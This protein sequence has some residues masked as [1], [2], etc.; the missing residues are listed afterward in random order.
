MIS[1]RSPQ[2]NWTQCLAEEI[3]REQVQIDDYDNCRSFWERLWYY[4]HVV[5]WSYENLSTRIPHLRNDESLVCGTKAELSSSFLLI[6][7][8]KVDWM[9]DGKETHCS[10]SSPLSS[11]SVVIVVTVDCKALQL[12]WRGGARQTPWELRRGGDARTTH[13]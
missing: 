4:K 3:L 11:L 1:G 8:T 10:V 12:Q 6:P 7:T 9:N 13:R 2:K 5:L